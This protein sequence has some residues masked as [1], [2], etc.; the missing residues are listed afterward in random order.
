MRARQ[1]ID[2]GAL[3]DILGF[4]ASYLHGGNAN[5]AVPLKWRLTAAAGGGTIAD[6]ASHVLDLVDWLIGPLQSLTSATQIAYPER[7]ALE[8][9]R[10]MRPVDVEDVVMILAK[11]QAGALGSIEATKLATGSEDELRLEIHRA[12]GALRF[13]GMDPHHLEFHDAT[14]PEQPAGGMRGWNRIDCGQRYPPPATPFPSPKA[15]IGWINSHVASL[16][17][18]LA[19]I[20]DGRPAEPSLAHGIR[21]QHLID[22]VR[23]SAA[24]KRWC[25][26]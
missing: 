10:K 15:A 19:A 16:A 17:N 23:C 4:R 18:F 2:A 21:I 3:G 8:D 22:R 9:S 11:T 24:E 25:D 5:P 20:A 14:A 7:P 26:V 12:R 13:N 6:L 1:L